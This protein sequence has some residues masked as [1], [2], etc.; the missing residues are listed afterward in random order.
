MRVVRL[1]ED[2]WITLRDLRLR[3]L[4]QDP[5]AFGSQLGREQGFRETHWRM[6]LRSS[7]WFAGYADADE[8]PSGLVDV[9][10]E[11]GAGP[12]DRHVVAPWVAPERRR[13]GLGATLLDHA[14]R[15]AQADGGTTVSLWVAQDATTAIAFY[16]AAGFVPTGTVMPHP[17]DASRLD[18]RWSRSL[19]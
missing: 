13:Q 2:E 4:T 6:R 5:D 16:R 3:A 18:E 19:G 14:C 7:A 15:W 11:P 8:T 17:R 12:D 10:E 1:T 9:I